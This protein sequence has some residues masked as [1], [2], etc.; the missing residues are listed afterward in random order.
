MSD[1]TKHDL[2]S[3]LKG[4]SMADWITTAEAAK[5]SGYHSKHIQRLV[6]AKKVKAQKWGIQWQISRSSLVAYMKAAEK[7][8]GKRG[9]KRAI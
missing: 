9:P 3:W 8:G 4:L 7:M 5:I 6:R 1:G 2:G